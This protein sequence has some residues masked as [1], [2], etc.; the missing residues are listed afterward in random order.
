[1]RKALII[2]D[3][4][5]GKTYK[6]INDRIRQITQGR[7]CLIVSAAEMGNKYNPDILTKYFKNK[8]VFWDTIIVKMCPENFKYATFCN[9][10]SNGQHFESEMV[11]GIFYPQFIFL[12]EK[13]PAF[14]GASMKKRFDFESIYLGF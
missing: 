5:G 11:S 3:V 10:I 14:K 7:T 2:Y 8:W 1:M 6:K 12:T 4:K 13:W 9:V